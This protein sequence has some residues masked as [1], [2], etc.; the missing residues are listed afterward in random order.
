MSKGKLFAVCIVWLVVLSVGVLVWKLLFAPVRQAAQDRDRQ[1]KLQGAGSPSRYR[2][3]IDFHLDSFSGYAIL[4]SEAFARELSGRGIRI[5]LHDDAADYGARIRA[6]QSGE[7]QLAVFTIDA[8]I[9]TSADLGELPASIV[10]VVDETT[11]ADAIV[12]YKSQVPNIDALNHAETRF[13]LTP[14]SPS[15]TLARVVMSRFNLDNLAEDPF[16]KVNDAGEVFEHYRRAKSTEPLAFVLWEPYVS[17]MLK[18]PQTHVVVDSSRFPSTI[19]DVI[20]A[21]RDFLLKNPDVVK[22]FVE[23]YLRTD[24]RYRHRARDLACIRQHL[25][26]KPQEIQPTY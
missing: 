18:N 25:Q 5:N 2:H 14:A 13:V 24:W 19:V 9:K 20:V 1:D 6:L 11:G 17:Q 21:N 3:G 22:A 16:Q 23:C 15:E 10:A 7:A 12:A 26:H 8:L 4:R